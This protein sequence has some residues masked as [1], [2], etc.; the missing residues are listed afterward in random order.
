MIASTLDVRYMTVPERQAIIE[1]LATPIESNADVA[2][3]KGDDALGMILRS[4]SSAMSSA[5]GELAVADI[6]LT[7]SVVLR[8][9]GLLT[10]FQCRHARYPVGA[11][12]H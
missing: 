5:A 2:T 1:L 12:L 7:E 11:V 9:L 10:A 6:I 3:E 8:A 4:V